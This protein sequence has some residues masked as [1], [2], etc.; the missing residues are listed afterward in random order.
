MPLILVDAGDGCATAKSCNM[1]TRLVFLEFCRQGLKFSMT[2]AA[3]V[4]KAWSWNSRLSS[5][6]LNQ[7]FAGRIRP[8][9]MGR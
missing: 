7:Q 6:I 8:F 9:I 3:K 5:S 4:E 1:R 2:F